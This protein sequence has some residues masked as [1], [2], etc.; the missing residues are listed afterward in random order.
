MSK[1]RIGNRQSK[2]FLQL[3]VARDEK[4]GQELISKMEKIA[5]KNGLSLN[6]VANMSMAAGLNMV[7]AKLREIHEPEVAA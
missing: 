1:P 6:D 5:E 3:R 7:D 2:D 4:R